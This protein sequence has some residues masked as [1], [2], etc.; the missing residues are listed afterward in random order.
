MVAVGCSSLVPAPKPVK[1]SATALLAPTQG[2][3]VS[4]ELGLAS[5]A[6]G[7]V[8]IQGK[9]QGLRPN[10]EHGFHVHEKGDCSSADASSAGGHFNP[11]GQP[12]G[13]FDSSAHHAGDLPSLRADTQGVATLNYVSRSISLGQGA[14]DVIGKSVIVHKNADDYTTQPAGNAG[15]RLA[16]GVITRT[17]A[18]N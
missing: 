11:T 4:G 18:R 16:C 7:A 10:S 5:D 17:P 15:P 1:I 2:S 13:H 3:Q 9:I 6:K 8:R 14:S 12:H